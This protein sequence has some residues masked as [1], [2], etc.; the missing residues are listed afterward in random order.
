MLESSFS[1]YD[2]GLPEFEEVALG[3]NYMRMGSTESCPKRMGGVSSVAYLQHQHHL[4]SKV[5]RERLAAKLDENSS[6]RTLAV[7]LGAYRESGRTP[8][9]AG[10]GQ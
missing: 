8:G 10:T 4:H 9:R 6:L 7:S 1:D 3:A 5:P 2:W